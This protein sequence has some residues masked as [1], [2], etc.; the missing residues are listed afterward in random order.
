M[1]ISAL[2][3]TGEKSATLL[4]QILQA[5]TFEQMLERQIFAERNE[6]DLVVDRQ[7]RTI[8]VDHIDRIVGVRIGRIDGFGEAASRR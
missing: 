2:P 8:M 6:M 1:R 7:D 5:E 3:V 4:G